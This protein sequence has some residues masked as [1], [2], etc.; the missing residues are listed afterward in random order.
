MLAD[1]LDQHKGV[2]IGRRCAYWALSEKA[3]VLSNDVK[4]LNLGMVVVAVKLSLELL[5]HIYKS[6][7][8][9]KI[10]TS[11]MLQRYQA[12]NRAN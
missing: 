2:K 8:L 6:S 1:T 9:R 7:V 5:R 10:S 12:R 11:W 4:K 3:K